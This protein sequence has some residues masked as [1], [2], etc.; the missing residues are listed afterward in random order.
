H[1]SGQSRKA[2]YIDKF[3]TSPARRALMAASYAERTLMAGFTSVRDVGGTDLV[4]IDLRDAINAGDVPGPR[5]FVAGKSLSITGGHADGTNG[6]LEKYV[7]VPAE[8][9]GVVDGTDSAVRAVRI[10]R[11]RGV[12]LI[13]ITATAGVL[14]RQADGTSAHFTDEEIRAIVET[15]DTFGLKVTAH[16]HGDEGMRRAVLNGVKSIEHGTYMSEETMDVM[17][18]KGAYLIPTITAGKS[19]ADSARIENYYIPIV[20]RKA[21]EVGPVIQGTFGKAFR[22]GVPIAFGTDAG[23]FPHGLNALEFGYMVEAGMPFMEALKTA[24]V[25]AATLLNQYDNFGSLEA[26]KYADIVAVQ[27]D[28]RA[29]ASAATRVSFVM[30]QGTVYAE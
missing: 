26:G 30:K 16:A 8:P 28:P 18:D 24:T 14:S 10:A 12:D 15:A 13:K 6:Y 3:T 21:M 5:M 7:G 27:E 4:D 23:V 1:L 25:N 17:I 2:G 9:D 29:D 11:K 20:A 22:R 19:V